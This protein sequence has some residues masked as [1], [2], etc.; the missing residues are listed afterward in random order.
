MPS[1][2][3]PFQTWKHMTDLYEA[4]YERY[5]DRDLQNLIIFNSI[6]TLITT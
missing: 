6:Y 4:L 2:C 5:K 3:F 1:G